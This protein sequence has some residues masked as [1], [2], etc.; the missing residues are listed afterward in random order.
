MCSIKPLTALMG[1]AIEADGCTLF[2][3][4]NT[5]SGPENAA[6]RAGKI[7]FAQVSVPG[8]GSP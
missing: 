7:E 3:C 8:T 2:I 6:N 1:A 4:T 5:D